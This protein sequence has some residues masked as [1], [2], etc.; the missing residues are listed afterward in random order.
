M[1]FL[2][3]RHTLWPDSLCN[4]IGKQILCPESDIKQF[5]YALYAQ[6]R[7]QS[8]KCLTRKAK[9]NTTA[10]ETVRRLCAGVFTRS[11][12]QHIIVF[13]ILPMLT[14]A[15]QRNLYGPL[16]PASSWKPPVEGPRHMFFF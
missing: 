4:K 2:L 9:V 6:I 15:C 13:L 14:C 12:T 1:H 16:F 7:A 11:F 3:K 10:E 8:L 5:K